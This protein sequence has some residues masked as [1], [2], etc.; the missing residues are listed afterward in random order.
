MEPVDEATQRLLVT[1]P[2]RESTFEI[3]GR[4]IGHYSNRS[5]KH[6]NSDGKKP[7]LQGTVRGCNYQDGQ[8]QS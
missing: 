8:L 4:S 7:K 3:L 2:N 6:S 1:N 5:G